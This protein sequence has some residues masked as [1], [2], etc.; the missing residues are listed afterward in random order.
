MCGACYQRQR[1]AQY[2]ERGKEYCRRYVITHP[3]RVLAS[4]AKYNSTHRNE[5]HQRANDKT[6][7]L[8]AM[9]IGAYGGKC[10]CC[11]ES[12]PV[13]LTIDHIHGGGQLDRR[14]EHGGWR[15]YTRLVKTGFPKDNYQLLCYN[16]N[17]SKGFWGECPHEQQRVRG[18]LSVVPDPLFAINSQL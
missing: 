2:P 10:V 9:V 7:L 8:K 4:T 5:L 6:R 3:D 1:H 18:S 17:L 13:F 12:N 15:F 11:G 14:G 16:C